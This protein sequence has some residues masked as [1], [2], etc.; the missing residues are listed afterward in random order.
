MIY[1]IVRLCIRLKVYHNEVSSWH[2]YMLDCDSNN[3][4]GQNKKLFA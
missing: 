2:P 4:L 1:I 3:D